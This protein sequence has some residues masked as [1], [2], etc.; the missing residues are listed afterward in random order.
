MFIIAN[1][2]YAVLYIAILLSAAIMIFEER[3]FQ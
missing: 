2:C 1:S 3:E